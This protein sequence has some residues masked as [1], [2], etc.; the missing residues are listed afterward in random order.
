MRVVQNVIMMSD[1]QKTAKEPALIIK[2]EDDF[3]DTKGHF[4]SVSHSPCWQTPPTKSW[5]YNYK[6]SPP[7]LSWAT[8]EL[9]L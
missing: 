1:S 8:S 9:R 5:S 6:R 4:G 2:K 7:T 3:K